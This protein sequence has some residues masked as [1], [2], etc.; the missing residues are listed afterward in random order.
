MDY[1]HFDNFDFFVHMADDIFA[2]VEDYAAMENYE[3]RHAIENQ[4]NKLTEQELIIHQLKM[5]IS[6]LESA[7]LWCG[8]ACFDEMAENPN[9]NFKKID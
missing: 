4:E 9:F 1:E 2:D 8:E 3:L 5:R 6:A 7:I